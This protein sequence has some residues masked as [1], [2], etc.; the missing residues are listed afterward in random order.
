MSS[1]TTDPRIA[2]SRVPTTRQLA[3]RRVIVRRRG[4]AALLVLLT[5][6]G[7]AVHV[8]RDPTI[9]PIE[10]PGTAAWALEHYGNP[11]AKRFEARHL[12]EI[13]FLGRAMFVHE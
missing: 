11:D 3:R 7:V 4:I 8:R 9:L 10:R 5:L 2:R 12:V 1:E 13:E 6:V